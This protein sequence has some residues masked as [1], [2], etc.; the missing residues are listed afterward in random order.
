MLLHD[1]GVFRAAQTSAL[2]RQLQ[3]A[4]NTMRSMRKHTLEVTV[5]ALIIRIVF[6]GFL[7]II[8]V[9]GPQNPILI[10]KASILKSGSHEDLESPACRH[11]PKARAER[12]Y[13]S[14]GRITKDSVTKRLHANTIHM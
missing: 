9:N 11:A 2:L 13:I 1:P 7:I 12:G 14:L 10:I 3:P 4:C 6:W 5:G 8:I